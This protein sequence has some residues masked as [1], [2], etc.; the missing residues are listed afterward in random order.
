MYPGTYHTIFM[1]QSIAN[2]ARASL[3]QCLHVYIYTYIYIYI[4][5]Y[6][7]TYISLAVFMY[8]MS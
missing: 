1:Y 6:R 2:V 8:I 4:Y 5:I 7:S 3:V